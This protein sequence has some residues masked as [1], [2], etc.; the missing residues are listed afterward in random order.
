VIVAGP[1]DAVEAIGGTIIGEV[2]GQ[3]LEI[4]GVLSVP[5]AEL[6]TA[7]E[8]AIPAALAG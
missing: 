7:Y 3:E 4:D 6:R 5:V 2:G 1:R 8:G